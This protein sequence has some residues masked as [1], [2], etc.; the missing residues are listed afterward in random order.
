[1]KKE[2]LVTNDDGFEAQ[3]INLVAEL[4]RQYGNVTVVAPKEPQSGKAASITLDRTLDI[5][6]K[7]EEPASGENGSIRVFVLTGTPVDCAKMGVNIYKSEGLFPDLL[8]SGIN[9]GSNASSAALY[10][11]TLGAAKEG[12]VYEIPSIGFSIDT[13]VPE[14]DFS[15]L[16]HYAK[17]ILDQYFRTGVSNGVY[18]NINFP[19]LPAEQ[20]KGVRLAHQGRGRWINEFDHRVNPRGRDYFWMVGEFIDV[21]TEGAPADADHR[22]LSEGYV[23]IVP[24]RIDTTD[25]QE[26]E[27]LE[28]LWQF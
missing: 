6:K 19:D 17:I 18:L 11:G 9:H 5:E 27:R 21:E 16:Q 7:R 20:I 12:T 1:M 4:M 3:G 2:I 10:S 14:P 24:H 22:L 25:Y 26:R 8:V 13:H 15:G 28:N 23:T